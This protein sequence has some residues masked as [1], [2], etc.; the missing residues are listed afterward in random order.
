MY[1]VSLPTLQS[2]NIFTINKLVS[3]VSVVLICSFLKY[4]L[5][6]FKL[7]WFSTK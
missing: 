2:V 3:I 5:S 7:V 4:T 6:S 1:D